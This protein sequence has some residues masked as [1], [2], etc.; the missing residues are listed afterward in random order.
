M[1]FGCSGARGKA[2]GLWTRQSVALGSH[3][4]TSLF[5]EFKSPQPLDSGLS[6]CCAPG[7]VVR[8]ASKF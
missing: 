2:A 3:S 8:P 6:T 7:R 1:C 5:F 4:H